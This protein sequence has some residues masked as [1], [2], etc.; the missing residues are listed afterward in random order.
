MKHHNQWEH[1]QW[2]GYYDTGH[3]TETIL[4]KPLFEIYFQEIEEGYVIIIKVNFRENVIWSAQ[5]LNMN[6][7]KTTSNRKH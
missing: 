6:D 4:V 3:I 7:T 2:I 5:A 1:R